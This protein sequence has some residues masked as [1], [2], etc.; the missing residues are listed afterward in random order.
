MITETVT[1]AQTAAL[2]LMGS[3]QAKLIDLNREAAS[4]LGAVAQP[5]PFASLIPGFDSRDLVA[6]SFDF[7]AKVLDANRTFATELLAAWAP[8]SS[9]APAPKP[10]PQPQAKA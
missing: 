8:V 2:D 7:A 9:P 3:V 6:Q 4:T 10:Q 1:A 5:L